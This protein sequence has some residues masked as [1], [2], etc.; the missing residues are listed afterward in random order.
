[1]FS[2][3]PSQ[4]PGRVLRGGLKESWTGPNPGWI[5]YCDAVEVDQRG[6]VTTIGGAP[7]DLKVRQN[8]SD[9]NL[10]PDLEDLQSRLLH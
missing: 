6:N 8:Q 10:R 2:I 4:V 9:S 5:Q 7:L 1:M 3:P